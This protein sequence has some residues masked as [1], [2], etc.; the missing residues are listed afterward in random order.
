M[1]KVSLEAHMIVSMEMYIVLKYFSALWI[2]L[3]MLN[4]SHAYSTHQCQECTTIK[5]THH[6]SNIYKHKLI[7]KST[8]IHCIKLNHIMQ[9]CI[10]TIILISPSLQAIKWLQKIPLNILYIYICNPLI[11]KRTITLKDTHRGHYGIVFKTS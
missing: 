11:Y 5:D 1:K 9:S 3:N 2:P 6:L 10:K 8:N 7:C 4:P